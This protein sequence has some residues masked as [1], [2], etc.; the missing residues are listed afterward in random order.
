MPLPTRSLGQTGLDITTMGLGTWAIGGAGWAYG[1]GPQDDASSLGAMR[2]AV[3]LGINWID[4]APAYGLGHAEEL[5]GR[6]LAE[7][8]VGERPFVFTKCG[9]LC[10]PARP[11]A[12]PKRDLRPET[13]RREC[14][15]SLQR[16]GVERIDLY[17]FH[18][19]DDTSTPVEYS[20]ETMLRLVEEGKIRAA[21]VCNFDVGLLELCEARG[22][23]AAVQ[24]PLSLIRRESAGNEIPWC[25]EHGTGVLCYSPMQSGL[26]TGRFTVA[27][28]ERLPHDDWRRQ[29]PEFQQPR[30]GR[31]LALGDAL[32]PIAQRHGSTV[33]AV[34]VAWTIQWPGVTGA[35][36]GARGPEQVDGWIGAAT[37]SLTP[38]D[39]DEIVTAVHRTGAGDGPARPQDVE[40]WKWAVGVQE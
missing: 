18:W 39:L 32:S 17:Q 8:P 22:H 30:L 1:W 36:V 14:E 40:T 16:L 24:L 2:R 5:V 23:V 35:I 15:A 11:F 25:V 19:P 12:E 6:F 29:N 21:A 7:L 37:L 28:V 33:P 10:D 9:L 26:L 31:N 27:A 34:A 4:T 38:E 3:V 20:W 13:I